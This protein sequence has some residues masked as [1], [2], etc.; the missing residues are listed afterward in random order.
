MNKIYLCKIK[1]YKINLDGKPFTVKGEIWVGSFEGEDFRYAIFDKTENGYVLG[2]T[3][4]T[5][6]AEVEKQTI[7]ITE[8]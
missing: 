1:D 5:E 7:S 4:S 3:G 8:I 6:K 2:G